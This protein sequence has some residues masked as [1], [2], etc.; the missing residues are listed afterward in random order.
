MKK[1]LKDI[2]A[3]IIIVLCL[4]IFIEIYEKYS[5]IDSTHPDDENEIVESVALSETSII[6]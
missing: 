4:V 6:W 1:F 2:I 3:F 5:A